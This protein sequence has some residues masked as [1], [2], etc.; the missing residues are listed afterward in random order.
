MQSQQEYIDLDGIRYEISLAEREDGYEAVWICPSCDKRDSRERIA[1]TADRAVELA[2]IGL[3]LHHFFV[4]CH[5]R[6]PK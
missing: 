2:Q 3:K 1:A 5:R 4:H 6:P